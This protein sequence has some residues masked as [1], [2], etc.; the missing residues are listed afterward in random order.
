MFEN[1]TRALPRFGEE[2]SLERINFSWTIEEALKEN[3]LHEVPKLTEIVVAGG[4]WS[5]LSSIQLKFD[6]GIESPTFRTRSGY[7]PVSHVLGADEF[8]SEIRVKVYKNYLNKIELIG[9]EGQAYFSTEE[10]HTSGDYV[11]HAIAE[12]EV[13]IGFHGA[14][15]NSYNGISSLGFI[16]ADIT[17]LL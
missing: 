10:Y 7:P 4:Y 6:N 14:K 8:L 17:D 1:K 3:M 9:E 5:A 12:H 2:V 11:S 16:V 15:Q 13:I